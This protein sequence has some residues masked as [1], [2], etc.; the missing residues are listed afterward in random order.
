[1]NKSDKIA[2]IFP[3]FGLSQGN[4]ESASFL[5]GPLGV[6]L[7]W[8]MDGPTGQGGNINSSTGSILRPPEELKPPE[9]FPKL[10]REYLA[11][12]EEH[13][14]RSALS[15]L[16]ALTG[17][18]EPEDT[19]WQI[20]KILR[21]GSAPETSESIKNDRLKWH[22]ILHLAVRLEQERR[23]AENTLRESAN[24]G[25][26]L[27]DALGEEAESPDIMKDISPSLIQPVAERGLLM[28]ICEA[29]LGLFGKLLQKETTLVTFHGEIY[30]FV[31]SLFEETVFEFNVIQELP[32]ASFSLGSPL[33]P[34]HRKAGKEGKEDLTK[35]LGSVLY[36]LKNELH[37]KE[38]RM[39]E[40]ITELVHSLQK[41][42]PP[43]EH[44]H[45]IR[46]EMCSLPDI[47][48]SHLSRNQAALHGF[49]GKTLV[50]L[51]EGT[52]NGE[53]TLNQ[54]T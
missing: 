21:E 12:M 34:T 22:L 49:S 40:K 44:S 50:F 37:Y 38:G 8:Y 29:W 52:E 39:Q 6:C 36:E 31:N 14:D 18:N 7:P 35:K 32:R 24:Q 9:D 42:L 26:P 28:H 16:S 4:L 25:S 23:E 43:G 19:R 11:W 15:F 47:R 33:S 1:M 5:F 20:Q 2:L 45:F 13:A 53:R 41:M 48:G 54:G 51:R 30:S 46:V 3:P 27:K 17:R 10:V